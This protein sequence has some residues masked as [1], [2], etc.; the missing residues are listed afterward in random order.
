MNKIT[1]LIACF[2]FAVF[3]QSET[4]NT[5]L[6]RTNLGIKLGVNLPSMVYSNERLYDYQSST[7][8]NGLFELFGEYSIIP[9]LSVRPG[10]KYT[11]RGQ[12][13][14]VFGFKYEYNAKY[15]ELTLPVVY[16]FPTTINISPYLLG[17]PVLGFVCGGDIGYSERG[18]ISHRTKL[19]KSNTSTSS[20]GLYLG[21]GLKYTLP[22]IKEKFLIVLGFEAGYHFGLTDKYSDK[23]RKGTAEA[24]NADDYNIKGT[25]K[26]RGLELGIT[27]TIPLANFKKPKQPEPESLL[28]PEPEL[29]PE[30]PPVSESFSEPE[31][32]EPSHTVDEITN[33]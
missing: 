14:D 29:E 25:R 20:F 3:A 22:P 17:G 6:D 19:N 15:I 26:H 8:A 4:E 30:S 7:Y 9:S 28:V 31:P 1:C 27:F 11:T 33:Q 18:E 23:E 32:E 12:H 10:I 5:F 24:L 2:S 16:T 13:L 21:E